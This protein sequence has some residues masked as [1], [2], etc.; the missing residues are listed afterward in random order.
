M[1]CGPVGSGHFVK[2]VHNGIEYGLMQAY[3]E[4]F[5]ILKGATSE[6][7]P[8]DER[9]ELDRR[10]HRRGVAA[11]QR[12][13]L[14]AARSH[15]ARAGGRSEARGFS[16]VVADSGEGRWTVD[17]GDRG[18]GAGDGA[19]G[20]ALR[21]LPLARRSRLRRPAACRRCA[22]ASAGISSRRARDHGRCRARRRSPRRARAAPRRPLRLRHLRR[23][24]RPDQA[25]AVAGAL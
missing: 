20:G 1:H 25:A 23:R 14:V 15:R 2:M 12:H 16:G 3:A 18:G 24:R 7:R 17:G 22:R 10:R 19:F 6:A 9:Y 5:A 13:F 21:A 11:R 4:G 8:P